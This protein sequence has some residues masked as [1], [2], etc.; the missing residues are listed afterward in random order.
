VIVANA[1]HRA[2]GPGRVPAYF[3]AYKFRPLPKEGTPDN[4]EGQYTAETIIEIE[5]TQGQLVAARALLDAGTTE[6]IV[7]KQFIRK[8]HAK[9]E[10]GKSTVWNTLGG[11]FK[12]KRK[13]LE[14]N[15]NCLSC[16]TVRK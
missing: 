9:T 16:L 15:S 7:F 5:N 8:G 12:M 4:S 13:A 1:A 11:K 6:S 3:E 14:W 10:K 2:P